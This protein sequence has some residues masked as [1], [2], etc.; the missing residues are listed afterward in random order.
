MP[1]PYFDAIAF[2]WHRPEAVEFHRALAQAER[3]FA[4][5]EFVYQQCGELPG[6]PSGRP[7]DMLWK[8]VLDH[9]TPAG[10]LSR[11]CDILH[12]HALYAAL[13]PRITAV[14]SAVDPLTASM[15]A[16]DQ[17]FLD[18]TRL[19]DRLAK[20]GARTSAARLLLVRGTKGSGKSWTRLMVEQVASA[21]GDRCIYLYE[22][23][24]ITVQD[25]IDLLFASL[26][27]SDIPDQ[28]GTEDAYYRKVCVR[29]QECARAHERT[30][31]QDRRWWIV[32][33]NLGGGTD[34]PSLDPRIK[35][36][37]DHLAL[38]LANPAFARWFRLVL[39]DYPDG[40]VPTKWLR[41]MFNEDRTSC[42]DIDIAVVHEFLGRWG[43]A[44]GRQLAEDSRRALAERI[45]ASVDQ[46][47]AA[48]AG[49]LLPHPPAPGGRVPSRL[50]RINDALQAALDA[51]AAGT[52]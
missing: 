2:P 23:L 48:S 15:I 17:I 1:H 46:P 29:M 45:I 30:A 4:R 52:P 18:R 51:L 25:V 37:F 32:A 9:V 43:E 34:G 12:G 41:E 50:Q 49:A 35:R 14:M 38:H 26:G 21:Y 36:F 22:G 33:D 5:I 3:S 40:A 47:P 7:A 6:L 42:D 27:A 44:R 20:L 10:L 11:L 24:V 28:L 13:R 8:H 19:R 39:L 16:D 31:V